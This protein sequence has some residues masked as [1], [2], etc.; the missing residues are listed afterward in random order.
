MQELTDNP[1]KKPVASV[2][3]KKPSGSVRSWSIEDVKAALRRRLIL[4]EQETD[5]EKR[6]E[7]L[8]KT[9][10]LIKTIRRHGWSYTSWAA[11]SWAAAV[12]LILAI[13][14]VFP[15]TEWRVL[16]ATDKAGYEFL[17]QRVIWGHALRPELRRFCPNELR[18]RFEQ[19]MTLESLRFDERG[20]CVSI[21]AYSPAYRIRRGKD[22]WPT[23]A[24]NC[25]Y[26]PNSA[27]P[28]GY[29]SVC[30]GRAQF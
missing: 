30:A 6:A 23:L 19:G 8:R 1:Q 29:S 9:W 22:H 20:E 11:I 26:S 12:S 25:H 18:P 27:V 3:L 5:P 21:A 24:R 10:P 4:A 16:E 13:L 14:A 17:L 15:R 7:I 28:W 2:G